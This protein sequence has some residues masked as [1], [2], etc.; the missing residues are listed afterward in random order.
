MLEKSSKIKGMIQELAYPLKGSSL[1]AGIDSQQHS[2]MLRLNTLLLILFLLEGTV[3]AQYFL[4]TKIPPWDFLGS[5]NTN[6]FLWWTEGSFF[7][8]VDWVPNSLAGYPAA[9][10]LQGSS[11]YLPVGIATLFGPFGLHSSAVVSAL[12]VAFG[13]CGTY[14]LVRSFRVPFSVATFAAVAGFFAVGYF[15]SAQHVDIV[16]GYAW[17]P[18]LLLVLSPHW[19]WTK[20]WSVPLAAVVLWQ[21]ATGIYPGMIF[22]TAYV[23]VVWVAVYQ[24][25]ERPS[26]RSYLVPLSVSTIAAVLLCAPRLI[27]YIRLS[28]D[29]ADEMTDT[30]KFDPAMVGTLLFGY[31]NADFPNDISMNTFFLPATVLALCWFADFGHRISRLGL[32]AG[33]PAFTLGMPFFPWFEATQSWPGLG[34]SRFTMNDFRVFILLGLVLLACSGMLCLVSRTSMTSS[35]FWKRFSGALALTI[36][37]L[38]TGLW[39][40]FTLQDWLPGFALLALVLSLILSSRFQWMPRRSAALPIALIVFTISSGVLWAQTT[41]LPWNVSRINAEI[42]TYGTTVED[43]MSLRSVDSPTMQRPARIPLPDGYDKN[44]ILGAVWNGSYY[45]GKD[46]VG[47]YINLKG[48]ETLGRLVASLTDPVS[49]TAFAEFLSAPGLVLANETSAETLRDCARSAAC[50]HMT[51]VPVGYESGD[52]RYQIS[53]AKPAEVVL[54]EAYY[55]GWHAEICKAN[56]C[57]TLAPTRSINGLVQVSLPEGNYFLQVLYRAPGQEAGWAGFAL[58]VAVMASGMLVR[59][60]PR[61]RAH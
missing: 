40:P 26:L 21:A 6:G 49:G 29:T 23:G 59:P 15:S 57:T 60:R 5:Y 54:N 35:V 32:A 45:S 2:K 8:P 46:A 37:L 55:T 39:G 51:V 41:R 7:D 13:F 53:T 48:S 22:T 4:G 14:A 52:L 43:L 47:G 24:W 20:I 11:W 3:F 17:A 33:I 31:G 34:L 9:L 28:D 36:V 38:V 58:G 19:P 25:Q 18:W 12:H 16:R 30:S 10:V 61:Q 1:F 42:E 44:T 50:G 27:P 56:G